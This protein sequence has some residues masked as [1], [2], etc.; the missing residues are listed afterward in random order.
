MWIPLIQ[1]T[2]HAQATVDFYE[3]QLDTGRQVTIDSLQRAKQHLEVARQNESVFQEEFRLR[4]G[5]NR[6]WLG[7][8]GQM[9][10]D[11]SCAGSDAQILSFLSGLSQEDILDRVWQDACPDCFKG[12]SSHPA[13]Q[14]HQ[15]E[16]KAQADC[17]GSR[18]K[19][20]AGSCPDCGRSD[21][22]SPKG[23][24]RVH[25]SAS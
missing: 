9:H 25:R 11:Q 7:K 19:A 18:R 5:W 10:T 2:E 23:R 16:I 21:V 24:T 22:V 3:K 17:P 6:V 15:K 13:W 4:H 8:N 20:Q 14:A 1:A 12:L